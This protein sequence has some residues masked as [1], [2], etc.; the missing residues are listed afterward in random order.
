MIMG[1]YEVFLDHILER[2][3]FGKM[4]VLDGDMLTLA[5]L[6]NGNAMMD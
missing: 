3:W 1:I 4:E 5:V 6:V 2:K